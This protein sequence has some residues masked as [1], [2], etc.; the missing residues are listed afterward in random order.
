MKKFTTRNNKE[1]LTKMEK[2]FIFIDR[3]EIDL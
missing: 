1:E 2:Y 3:K